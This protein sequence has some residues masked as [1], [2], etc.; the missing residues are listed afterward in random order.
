M[1]P[2]NEGQPEYFFLFRLVQWA[3][4]ALFL[5]RAIEHL[6]WD[7][8]FRA[9]LWDEAWMSGIVEQILGM[10]WEDYI[11]NE[12]VDLRI[13]QVIRIHGWFYLCCAF[14]AL[15]IRRL[16]IWLSKVL[17]L[18]SAS[19]VFL[20]FLFFKEKFY[21]IGQFLEYTLQFSTPVFLVWLY[22]DQHLSNRLLLAMKIA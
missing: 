18:G 21:S 6:F 16:P 11:T 4:V 5:G 10:R 8:P 12:Q 7:A 9:L 2:S 3:A 17:Y 19:L 15:A 14:L 13:E 20:S 22:R 1:K